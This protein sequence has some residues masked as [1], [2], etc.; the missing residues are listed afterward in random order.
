MLFKCG[1]TFYGKIIIG[2]SGS[3]GSPI[4]LASYSTGAKPV[5]TGFSSVTSWTNVSG[6][7]W[8]STNAVTT[9][10]S[11]NM[12]TINN[13]VQPIGRYPKLTDANSGYL[14]FQSHS[15]TS[16]ITSNAISGF[17]SYMGGE[18]VIRSNNWI[19]DR[20]TI[21]GQTSTTISYTPLPSPFGAYEPLN[22]FGFFFQN[23]VNACTQQGD[24]YF[25]NSTK[26]IGMYSV[27]TPS[28][29]QVATIDTL[30]DL[31]SKQ[32]IT[33]KNISFQ[34][35]NLLTFNLYQTQ[36]ISID[37]CDIKFAGMNAA[38]MFSGNSSYFTLTNSNVSYV[39]N[40]GFALNGST[41]CSITNNT[42]SNIGTIAGMGVGGDQQYF[43]MEY[44]GNNSNIQYNEVSNVGYIPIM[45]YG[46]NST[47]QN[48]YVHDFNTVKQDG[49]GIYTPG[50]TKPEQLFPIT[51]F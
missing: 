28:G 14:T 12:I 29:V 16:S 17:P 10:S 19:L 1:D 50:G 43:G 40:N 7:I 20:G 36:H 46:T 21:T 34:G 23:H 35:S 8:Q 3:S 31:P 27:G 2:K 51:L 39:N 24:W 48:N 32:Y 13:T 45:F 38:V 47:I 37:N 9:S 5:I 41:N 42:I 44:I 11:L 4:V 49:G 15:G 33:F 22:G 30:V 26:K 25:D 6:N 18:V